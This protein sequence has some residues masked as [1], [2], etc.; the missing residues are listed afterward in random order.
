MTSLATTLSVTIALLSSAS[1]E[2]SWDYIEKRQ[3]HQRKG[4]EEAKKTVAKATGGTSSPV[5]TAAYTTLGAALNTHP[6]MATVNAAESAAR[7]KLKTAQASKNPAL[8]ASARAEVA[9]TA[10]ARFQKAASI[11]ELAKLIDAWRDAT[12]QGV[13]ETN[14]PQVEKNVE[15]IEVG[16]GDLFE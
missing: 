3:A 8:M 10:N 6:E 9:K 2:L 5:A 13:E 15:A 11:P 12:T 7:Q 4:L 14:S 1:A 16:L